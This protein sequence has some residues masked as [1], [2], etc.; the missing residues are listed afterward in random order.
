MSASLYDQDF[1]A[2]TNQQAA[3]LRAGRLGEADLG[4]IAE[5]MESMGL[6]EKRELVN[7]LVVLMAHLLKWQLPPGFRG[8]SWRLSIV[9]QRY[10][11]ADHLRDNPS[12]KGGI[13]EAMTDAYRLA[14]IAAQKETG[15]PA[16]A[17][18]ADCP[19]EA[20][21]VVDDHF[22]PGPPADKE[23]MRS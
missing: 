18:P 9:E 20:A 15:L 11:L 12:L 21:A 4:R 17:F 6:S 2:W 16:T 13:P 23:F 7:R 19:W 14:L 3:L 22:M 1:Y 10:R 8:T 5:E